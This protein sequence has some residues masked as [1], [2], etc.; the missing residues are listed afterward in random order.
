M[1]NPE[2]PINITAGVWNKI[3][4][5]V[6]GTG[7][8]HRKTPCDHLQTYR[9]TGDPAPIDPTEGIVMFLNYSYEPYGSDSPID[10]YVLPSTDAVLRIDR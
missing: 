6:I 1:Q 3:A 8:I 10:I 4:T 2:Y 9:L 7:T 5:A